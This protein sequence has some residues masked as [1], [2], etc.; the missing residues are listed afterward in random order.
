MRGEEQ[1]PEIYQGSEH[2]CT[3]YMP[4]KKE[5]RGIRGNRERKRQRE[6][7]RGGERE[8]EEEVKLLTVAIKS[9]IPP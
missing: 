5:N 6:R 7:E 9:E 4:K 8:E 3:V 2:A 1:R